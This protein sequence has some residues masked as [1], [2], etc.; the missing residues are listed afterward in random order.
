M[1]KKCVRLENCGFFKR[2]EKDV[3]TIKE[4]WI[5]LFCESDEKAKHCKR[6]KYFEEKGEP[7]VDNMTPTGKT[8]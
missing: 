2:Y 5:H 4:G 3:K 8:F 6:R 7:P 1:D